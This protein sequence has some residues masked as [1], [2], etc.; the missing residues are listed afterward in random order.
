METNEHDS[1]GRAARLTELTTRLL[2]VLNLTA[3][4]AKIA[5]VEI[6][7]IPGLVA[8]VMDGVRPVQAGKPGRTPHA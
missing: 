2:T 6:L 5:E 8:G 3:E 4:N 1:W 7:R